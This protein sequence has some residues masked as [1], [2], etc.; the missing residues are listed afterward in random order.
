MIPSR[1]DMIVGYEI[2]KEVGF[3]LEEIL[4]TCLSAL[5]A[6]TVLAW[7]AWLSQQVNAGFQDGIGKL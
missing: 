7:K 4:Q 2:A 5:S 6:C 3:A 1:D